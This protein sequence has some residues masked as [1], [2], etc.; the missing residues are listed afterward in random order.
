MN[1]KE[2]IRKYGEIFNGLKLQRKRGLSYYVIFTLRRL[3]F[4]YII[5]YLQEYP[6]LQVQLNLYIQTFMILYLGFWRPWSNPFSNKLEFFNEIATLFIVY[7]MA[8]FSNFYHDIEVRYYL[9][10]NTFIYSTY[11]I[12]AV[13]TCVVLLQFYHTCKVDR[14]KR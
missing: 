11:I 9:L 3:L 10:G 5:V 8:C 14:R 13:N 7:H 1:D 12:I 2:I 6:W 4:A